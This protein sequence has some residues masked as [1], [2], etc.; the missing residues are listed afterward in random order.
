VR[1]IWMVGLLTVNAFA[2]EPSPAPAIELTALSQRLDELEQSHRILQRQLELEKEK[3]AEKAK[4]TP[5]V[6]FT[7]QGFVL[8]TPDGKTTLKIRGLLQ[9]DG[10]AFFGDEK[11]ALTDTLLLRR[12]RPIIDA[13]FFGVLDVRLM[14]DFGQNTVKLFDAYIDLH[15]FPWLRLRAGKF[16]PPVGLERLQ[17][18][19]AIRFPE[20]ALP[21]ALVP[22]RDVGAQL[23]GE[24]AGGTFIWAVGAF[25]GVVDGSDNPDIDVH[26]GKDFEA[27]IFLHPFRPLKNEWLNNLGVGVAGTYGNERGSLTSTGLATYKTPG[28]ATFFSFFSDATKADATTLADGARWR[29]SPQLY[30]YAGP[31][32]V[33]AE[34]VRA[35]QEVVKTG[36]HYTVLA[37]AW[38][39]QLSALLTPGDKETH[40]LVQPK[41]PIGV[42]KGYGAFELVARYHELHLH[43]DGNLPALADYAKSAR[44]ARAFGV[45]LNWWANN[46]FRVATSF[47]HIDFKGGAAKNQDRV[48]EDVLIGRLQA[49]W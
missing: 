40:D 9:V 47:E 10:R 44:Q 36:K 8:K 39:V 25:N 27:R 38:Q 19:A 3:S 14:P 6:A 11:H 21:T 5:V 1:L 22:N 28:Q 32:G 23:W 16:K 24:V 13:T 35:S 49:M 43:A 37:D 29:A 31:I 42:A 7:P 26:D 12:V 2:E 17:S 30:Y 46:F 18:A 33:L 41:R 48:S 45:A 34:Y 20:R 15:P 4:D